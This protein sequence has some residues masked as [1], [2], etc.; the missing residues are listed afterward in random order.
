M[1]FDG[2]VVVITGGSRGIGRATAELF[3]LEGA[4]V[5]INGA[6]QETVDA[7]VDDIVALGGN[8]FPIVGDVG[9]RDIVDRLVAEVLARHGHI[10]IL[11][12]NAGITAPGSAE[13]YDQFEKIM[14]I[15][16]NGAFYWSQTV[17]ARAMIPQNYGVIVNVSSLGGQQ[18]IRG[19][20]GYVTS[21]HAMLGLTRAFSL[22]WSRFN[23]RVNAL[24]PGMTRSDMVAQFAESDP[25]Q[26]SEICANI[27]LGRVAEPVEQARALLFLSSD[28]AS[29]ITGMVMNVDGGLMNVI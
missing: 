6:H 28:D 4:I 17:A 16:V 7:T 15:N 22:D 8:A 5:A 2:K 19:D 24:A 27:P 3:A 18:A 13:I 10:D 21:K 20:V 12:N 25:T 1:R 11:V 14:R 9:D 23:I 29:Y 26:F